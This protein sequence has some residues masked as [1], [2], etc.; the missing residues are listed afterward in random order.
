MPGGDT[1]ITSRKYLFI[2]LAFLLRCCWCSLLYKLQ[3]YYILTHKLQV[4]VHLR[5]LLKYWL[6]SCLVQSFCVTYFIHTNLYLLSHYT[7]IAPPLFLFPTGNYLFVLYICESVFF[8]FCFI[9]FTFFNFLDC[10]C[11]WYHVAFVFL[12]FT[13]LSII[14]SKSIHVVANG[15]ISFFFLGGIVRSA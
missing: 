15:K 5:L 10:T 12:W 13:S 7:C 8:C 14:L 11:K 1:A 9:I 2:V 6:Y 3:V 4:I